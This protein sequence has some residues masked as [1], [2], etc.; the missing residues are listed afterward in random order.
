MNF[1][2][3]NRK[4][5]IAMAA[6]AAAGILLIV[7]SAVPM[8][9]KED[10]EQDAKLDRFISSTE[11]RLC[12]TVEKIDGAGSTSVFITVTDTYETVYASNSSINRTSAGNT[13]EKQ[14]AFSSG[15]SYNSA[16]VVVKELC[17]DIKGVLIVCEGG[18]NQSVKNEI[19]KSV[20]IALGISSSKIHVTGGKD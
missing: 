4:K 18:N 7:F 20:S 10:E 1:K 13:S 11:E 17:P 5:V 3:E 9:K 16:P 8:S 15:T 19:T 2:P 14:I 6:A 12:R